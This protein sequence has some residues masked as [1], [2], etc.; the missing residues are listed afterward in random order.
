MLRARAPGGGRV[1]GPAGVLFAAWILTAPTPLFAAQVDVLFWNGESQYVP[2][3]GI[4]EGANGD[5]QGANEGS[6]TWDLSITGYS[7]GWSAGNTK[8]AD[9]F[10]SFGPS[11]LSA[12]S[13]SV[14]F[15]TEGNN[16]L[17]VL[18]VR[19]YNSRTGG[20]AVDPTRCAPYN[21]CSSPYMSS[22]WLSHHV[23][24]NTVVE[25]TPGSGGAVR[26]IAHLAPN[27]PPTTLKGPNRVGTLRVASIIFQR[28]GNEGTTQIKSYLQS[29][30]GVL[31][32][33]FTFV[34]TPP[35]IGGLV[36]FI[37]LEDLIPAL[38]RIGVLALAALLAG[39]GV[40]RLTRSRGPRHS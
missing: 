4:R 18:A 34:E 32:S 8:Q 38:P 31:A 21:L 22:G 7:K 15:D 5:K 39:S 24:R 37:P 12:S 29:G 2:P 25:S 3:N 9:I 13:I 33:D 16:L 17:D 19:Q 40:F 28:T 27:E 35:S 14:E 26:R 36:G 1:G 6:Q 23:G 11:G 10:I 30:D 20:Y